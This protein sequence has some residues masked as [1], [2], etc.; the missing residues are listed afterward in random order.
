M[1]PLAGEVVFITGAAR[2]IGAGTARALA[3]RGAR[4]I[5][6]DV[7]AAP[8]EEI[9]TEIGEDRVL[10]LA[11]DV[12]DLEAMESAAAAG[13]ERFGGID[14]VLANAGVA[15]YGSVAAVDPAMFKRFWTSI[16]SGCFTPYGPGLRGGRATRLLPDRLRG[17]R[18][19]ARPGAGVLLHVQGGRRALREHAAARGRSPRRGGRIR[20][21]VVDRHAARPGRQGRS[22]VV[23]GDA[24]NAPGAVG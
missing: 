18:V 1:S 19:R 6:V 10:S 3:A 13:I 20:A 7:D 5:L 9:T 8:L 12:C 4:L 11:C 23:P 21:H 22:R 14:L 16:C 24:V 17:G 15:S 2:G